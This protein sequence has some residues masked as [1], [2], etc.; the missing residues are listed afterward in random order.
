MGLTLSFP[1]SQVLNGAVGIKMKF[2][3]Q[4]S[5]GRCLLHRVCPAQRLDVCSRGCWL[6]TEAKEQA[7]RVKICAKELEGSKAG[8][9]YS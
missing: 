2:N 1:E 7:K 3:F 8:G 9:F 4:R 5:T 6:C